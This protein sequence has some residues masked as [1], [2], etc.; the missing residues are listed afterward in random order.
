MS[1]FQ[2]HYPWTNGPLIANAAMGGFAGPSLALAVNRAGG[3]GFIGAVN[4][5][6]KL[7]QQLMPAKSL[8]GNDKL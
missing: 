3:I 6:V 2:D 7:D 8:L 1:S 5:M 4:D